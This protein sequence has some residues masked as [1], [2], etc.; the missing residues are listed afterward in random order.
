MIRSK[1]RSIPGALSPE[2]LPN[3]LSRK[4]REREILGRWPNGP[5]NVEGKA[6]PRDFGI[7]PEPSLARFE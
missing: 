6:W 1:N 7:P 4:E 5:W 2:E 3:R